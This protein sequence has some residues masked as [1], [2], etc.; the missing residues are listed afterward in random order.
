MK[1]GIIMEKLSYT[2]RFAEGTNCTVFFGEDG[3]RRKDI[4]RL[5]RMDHVEE[6]QERYKLA[7]R[8]YRFRNAMLRY[9]K[10]YEK[11]SASLFDGKTV[12]NR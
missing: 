5:Q 4:L 1:G 2:C 7:H 9:D 11:R 3:V 6:L 10:I 8:D 12:R